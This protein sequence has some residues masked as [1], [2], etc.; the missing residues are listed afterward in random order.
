MPPILVASLLSTHY[1]SVSCQGIPGHK[2]SL[3]ANTDLGTCK[4]LVSLL[5]LVFSTPRY[6]EWNGEGGSLGPHSDYLSFCGKHRAVV[7]GFFFFFTL[8]FNYV[9]WRLPNWCHTTP[10]PKGRPIIMAA[11]HKP[12]HLDALQEGLEILQSNLLWMP[13][14]A[15][16]PCSHSARWISGG[17]VQ[18]VKNIVRPMA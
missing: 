17:N 8:T 1:W 10:R 4:Y 13:R 7:N 6:I 14:R 3:N 2:W 15:L 11:Q 5:R 12:T 16:W 9:D 18:S